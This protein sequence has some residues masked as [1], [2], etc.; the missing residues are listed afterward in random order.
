MCVCRKWGRKCRE[1]CKCPRGCEHISAW[2]VPRLCKNVFNI[3]LDETFG[4]EVEVR[5]NACFASCLA[6]PK[7]SQSFNAKSL[8]AV[9]LKDFWPSRGDKN[10]REWLEKLE[11]MEKGSDE[12]DK[13]LQ[14]LNRRVLGEGK[15]ADGWWWWSW[16]KQSWTSYGTT[17]HCWVCGSCRDSMNMW[18][19]G[20]CR[21]C[22]SGL[23]PCSGCGGRP[24]VD[25]SQEIS[26]LQEDDTEEHEPEQ[27]EFVDDN[28]DGPAVKAE[29][30][31]DQ[32]D[33]EDDSTD[34]P[35]AKRVMEWLRK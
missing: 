2:R 9:L 22:R 27:R 35:A 11:R 31:S 29:Y 4:A 10:L 12:R 3:E 23:E 1:T 20:K 5:A 15:D 32:Q 17:R 18:H 14:W 26:D 7:K 28:T 19:C 33:F 8:E 30:T 16:C 6:D 25:G 34:E 21:K 13:H 24:D